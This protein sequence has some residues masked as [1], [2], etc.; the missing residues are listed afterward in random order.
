MSALSKVTKDSPIGA[1]GQS[2]DMSSILGIDASPVVGMITLFL[3]TNN[4]GDITD[5]LF[6]MAKKFF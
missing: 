6:N 4:D 2:L 1:R 5:D 3:D